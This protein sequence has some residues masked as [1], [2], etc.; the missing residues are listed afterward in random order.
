MTSIIIPTCNGLELLASCVEAIRTH[1][2]TPYE[3]IVADNG[4]ADGTLEYCIRERLTFVSF[5]DNAGFP[6]ACNAGLKLAAGDALLLLNNDVVV[7]RNWLDNMLACLDS[8]PDTG[9]VGPCSNYV[10]GR[11]QAAGEYASMEE[12]HSWAVERN[13]PDSSRWVVLERLVGFCFLFKREL[14]QQIGYL[15]ERFSPGHYEDDDY[16]YRARLAGYRLVI[17]GDTFVHHHGSVSFKKQD[18]SVLAGLI[19]RN[20]RKFI[21][22]WGIDP[23]QYI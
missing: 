23:R 10:S 5:A 17:A 15:D 12:F 3:I 11:Q 4:S 8:T 21:E 20:H 1:T 13:L 16:C 14:L 2:S 7:S 22:K 9:I 6:A 18:S 19:D